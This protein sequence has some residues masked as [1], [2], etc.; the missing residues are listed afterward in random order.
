MWRWAP[1]HPYPPPIDDLLA[2]LGWVLAHT[3]ELGVDPGRVGL[4]GVVRGEYR[5]GRGD[6]G[7][8]AG[9]L[10]SVCGCRR[11]T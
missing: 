3:D 4:A 10:R 11:W 6:P 7:T 8:I 5:G 9:L 2:A 1:E